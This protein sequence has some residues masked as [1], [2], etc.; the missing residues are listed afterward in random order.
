MISTACWFDV[1]FIACMSAFVRLLASLSLWGLLGCSF[2]SEGVSGI[3]RENSFTAIIFM[4][5]LY[6]FNNVGL[7]V[8]FFY[9]ID[10]EDC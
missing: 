4:I 8:L 3:A 9:E 5:E 6:W 1:A 2:H 7:K 10:C